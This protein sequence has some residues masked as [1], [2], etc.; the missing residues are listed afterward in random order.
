MTGVLVSPRPPNYWRPSLSLALADMTRDKLTC[1]E[2]L[3]DKCSET[4]MEK[5]GAGRMSDNAECPVC[6]YGDVGR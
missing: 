1:T 3:W 2:Y 6:L 4:V 5:S